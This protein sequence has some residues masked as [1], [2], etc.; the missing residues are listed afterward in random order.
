MLEWPSLMAALIPG[1]P[2]WT[3]T[4]S[5]SLRTFSRTTQVASGN[6]NDE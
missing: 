6:R 3:G 2:S 1:H 4:D 5:E